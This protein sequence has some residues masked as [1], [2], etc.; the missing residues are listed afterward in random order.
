MN[1]NQSDSSIM[2][3]LLKKKNDQFLGRT[4]EK[5]LFDYFVSFLF[6]LVVHNSI[7]NLLRIIPINKSCKRTDV[8]D[9]VIAG[10]GGVIEEGVEIERDVASHT[11]QSLI[12]F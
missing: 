11:V 5:T 1:F 12:T 8:F 6:L 7:S 4:L 9:Y 10:V 2:I 3:K